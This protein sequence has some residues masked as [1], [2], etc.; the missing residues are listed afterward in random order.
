MCNNGVRM[1]YTCF[2][3]ANSLIISQESEF[4]GFC[5]EQKNSRNPIQFQRGDRLHRMHCESLLRF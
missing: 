1:N 2:F 4:R 3:M 5:F